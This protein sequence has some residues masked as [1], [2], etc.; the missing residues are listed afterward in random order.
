MSLSTKQ[1]HKIVTLEIASLQ[2]VKL[3]LELAISVGRGVA[4]GLHLLS[5]RSPVR[6]L[7]NG[8]HPIVT[9]EQR[10]ALPS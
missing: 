9:L 8:N 10:A 4:N 1:M 7:T 6:S 5:D 2:V 3:S